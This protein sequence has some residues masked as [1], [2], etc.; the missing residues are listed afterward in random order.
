MKNKKWLLILIIALPSIFWLILESSTIN[1]KKLPF[2]GPKKINEAGDTLFYKVNASLYNNTILTELD[3][4]TF[5]L[6]AIAFVSSEYRPDAYRLTGLWEYLN[7]KK[8]KIEHI[9]FILVTELDNGKSLA[10]DELHKLSENQ[11]VHF[12]NWNIQGFD[13]LNKA[14][15]KHKPYYVDYSFF[16]LVDA[17]RHIRGYYDA[18]YVSEMKRLIDEYRHLR[19][20]E[21]KQKLID[22]DKI[23]KEY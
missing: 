16:V 14:Y 19:L 21:E 17:E 13:S 22:N 15:F 4:E 10:M 18:R 12:Y 9:P 23:T 8:D 20:K 11:N 6:Y 5:P 7:Y 2:Y 1:S 3:K